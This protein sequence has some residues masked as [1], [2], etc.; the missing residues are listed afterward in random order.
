MLRLHARHPKV[1]RISALTGIDV[2]RV[3]SLCVD[4]FMYVDKHF[5]GSTTNLNSTGFQ[6]VLGYED[7][8]HGEASAD[9]RV[10]LVDAFL[11]VEFLRVDSGTDL[12]VVPDF[13]TYFSSSA[14][15]RAL[16]SKQKRFQR[17]SPKCRQ[18][19]RQKGDTLSSYSSS[20]SGLSPGGEKT[21]G[22]GGLGPEGDSAPIP[23]PDRIPQRSKRLPMF[24]G[25]EARD[26]DAAAVDAHFEV[27]EPDGP[28]SI[29]LEAYIAAMGF[30]PMQAIHVRR[31]AET[32]ADPSS[33]GEMH[34]IE[35]LQWG[36]A[37]KEPWASVESRARSNARVAGWG[38]KPTGKRK[39]TADDIVR[40][41][42]TG[43]EP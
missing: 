19:G 5:T 33:V 42:K 9:Q 39:M 3:L 18:D 12:L 41:L 37:G 38:P 4:W 30:R 14:K 24:A 29:A 32:L 27:V 21:G 7:V 1:L 34:V 40:Q 8:R 13:D 23:R 43:D 25:G 15:R 10:S 6:T 26:P 35:A 22:A 28:V 36:A 11:D 17:L 31:Q 16:K 2:H 20:H